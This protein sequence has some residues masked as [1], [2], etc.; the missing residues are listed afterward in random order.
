MQ[1]VCILCQTLLP[2]TDH[3]FGKHMQEKHAMVAANNLVRFLLAC[4]FLN[5]PERAL[6]RVRMERRIEAHVT[7]ELKVSE[8]EVMVLETQ[9]K[10]A[11]TV[12]VS[13]FSSQLMRA[14][15][16][17][18]VEK[19]EEVATVTDGE[20]SEEVLLVDDNAS[21]RHRSFEQDFRKANLI[22]SEQQCTV[23]K[24][25]SKN[26]FIKCRLCLS[27]VR[28]DLFDDHKTEHHPDFNDLTANMRNEA[29]AATLAEES[30][31]QNE[32]V[33]QQ[34]NKDA[35]KHIFCKPCQKQFFD[36]VLF[37]K[38][39]KDPEHVKNA[40][41]KLF[42][43]DVQPKI[44]RICSETL[45]S[46][47]ALRL[48]KISKHNQ[49]VETCKLCYVRIYSKRTKR[50]HEVEYHKADAHLFNVDIENIK[51]DS[52]CETCGMKFASEEIV[53]FHF[54]FVHS[55]KH[56]NSTGEDMHLM[57]SNNFEPLK[58]DPGETV[59]F[60]L[61]NQIGKFICSSCGTRIKDK[62]KMKRHIRNN[63]NVQTT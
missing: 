57:N 41:E 12:A 48:H 55:N 29:E 20:K 49:N 45:P 36:G 9:P 31:H 23:E 26:V 54:K 15:A 21:D 5:D 37:E 38:H 28:K 19:P 27:K 17:T 6:L 10:A 22:Q 52:K 25:I 18:K 40:S 51:R 14:M 11:P 50:R 8:L 61:D 13:S 4:H 3:R 63:H 47:S 35:I 39:K 1:L 33:G 43:P 56:I 30:I 59:T 58:K 42:T 44:C 7:S 16:E 32:N 34:I 24:P 53:K 2:S 46:E 62:W 60:W